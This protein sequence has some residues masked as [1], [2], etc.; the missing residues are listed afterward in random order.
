[1]SDFTICLLGGATINGFDC[2][3]VIL[4]EK[5]K[6]HFG[7]LVENEKI[8]KLNIDITGRLPVLNRLRLKRGGGLSNAFNP[9]SF[10]STICNL[11]CVNKINVLQEAI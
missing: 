2:E 9:I 8:R 7:F 4:V 3:K 11:V 5:R 10:E 6:A 1:M